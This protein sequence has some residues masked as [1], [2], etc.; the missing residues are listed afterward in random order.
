MSI[1]QKLETGY[2]Q[3]L[4][5]LFLLFAT[6]AIIFCVVQGIN[7]LGNHD[8]KPA[9]VTQKI[10]LT[11]T[12][13]VVPTTQTAS[14]DPTSTEVAAKQKSDPLLEDLI[15]VLSDIGKASSPDFTINRAR[16]VEIYHGYEQDTSLG[17]PFV[18]QLVAAL[19]KTFQRAEVKAYFKHNMG[20]AFSSTLQH[21]A[22]DYKRQQGLV[23]TAET[24]ADAAAAVKR[25]DAFSSLYAA[26]VL[27]GVFV[28]LIL[29][30]VLLKIERNLRTQRLMPMGS[31]P[32]A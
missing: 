4:R 3:L 32:V 29:L 17:K 7:Y 16:V 26:G 5:V 2:L 19:P 9:A 27:F 6:A 8:A 1:I 12:S 11:G 13:F 15:K 21:F 28:G 24:D 31:D 23:Q 20:E 22:D 30:I 10:E 18:R 25:A 14:G